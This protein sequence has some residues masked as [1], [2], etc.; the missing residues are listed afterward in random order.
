MLFRS[1][2]LYED[3]SNLPNLNEVA[4]EKLKEKSKTIKKT[5][6]K[7]NEET[8][9]GKKEEKGV[10]EKCD[11]NFKEPV[12]TENVKINKTPNVFA[13]KKE[14]KKSKKEKPKVKVYSARTLI[15]VLR[16]IRNISLLLMTINYVYMSQVADME[17]VSS[18]AHERMNFLVILSL[19]LLGLE[20]VAKIQKIGTA[21]ITSFLF[22]TFTEL[23][24]LGLNLFAISLIYK[25]FLYRSSKTEDLICFLI[26]VLPVSLLVGS[27]ISFSRKRNN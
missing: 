6:V 19:S 10:E 20:A 17:T 16:K 7:T 15:K 14:V 8:N 3:F 26:V 27:I 24:V 11:F 18:V 4:E 23:V 25:N 2:R 21:K 13:G 12:K 9:K 1:G 5:E 22:K